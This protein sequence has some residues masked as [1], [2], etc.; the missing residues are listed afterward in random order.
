MLGGGVVG[1]VAYA[2]QAGDRGQVDDGAAGVALAQHLLDLV[3]HAPEDAEHVCG[4]HPLE[5]AGGLVG[6]AAGVEGHAGV[7]DGD[8]EPAEPF[9]GGGDQRDD[10]LLGVDVG[11]D[12]GGFAAVVADLA[13]DCLSRRLATA[14]HDDR[15]AGAGQGQADLLAG[16]WWLR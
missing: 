5:A 12:E 10:G 9:D 8:V 4:E 3:L 13:G 15:M 1:C 14:G 6:Q 11:G 7:V 2:A 16:R